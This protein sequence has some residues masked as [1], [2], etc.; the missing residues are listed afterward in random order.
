MKTPMRARLIDL[1]FSLMRKQRVTLELDRDFREQFEHLKDG[2]VCL[3]IKKWREPRSKDANAYCWVLL[4]KLA[5]ALRTTKDELY[6]LYVRRVGVFRDFHLGLEEAQSFETAWSMLGTGWITEQ[7]DYTQDGS[8]VVIRAYYGSSQYNTKQMSR[9][10]DEL[11]S[12]CKDHGI[13]TLTPREL[14]R[15]KEEWHASGNKGNGNPAQS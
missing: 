11:V 4:D 8:Q 6:R 13:E 3:E 15:M 12:D 2:D 5:A 14:A 10:I 1:S 9:L 7:V